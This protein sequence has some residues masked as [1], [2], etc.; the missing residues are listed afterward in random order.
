MSVKY[1]GTVRDMNNTIV[2]PMYGGDGMDQC[3]MSMLNNFKFI[4]L[5]ESIFRKN[6]I[7]D[8]NEIVDKIKSYSSEINIDLIKET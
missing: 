8:I 7:D 3:K 2:Q 1:D 6:N 5:N 4:Q